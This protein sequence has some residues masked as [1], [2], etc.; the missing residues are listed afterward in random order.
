MDFIRRGRSDSGELK[1]WVDNDGASGMTSNPSIFE[2]AIAGSHDYDTTIHSLAKQN[3]T[4][5]DIFQSLSV[6]D[7]QRAADIFRPTYDRL[8][9][10]DG[11]VSLEVSPA[12]AHDTEAT[13]ARRTQALDS[14]QPAECDDQN[15]WNP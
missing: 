10:R 6:E 9:G 3:K 14:G 13:I 4:S 7:I 1:G 2:K 5:A 11:F 12:M 8:N 15:S